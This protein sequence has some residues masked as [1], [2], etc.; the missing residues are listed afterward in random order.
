MKGFIRK[1]VRRACAW[2][3]RWPLAGGCCTATAT[4]VDPCWPERYNYMARQDGRRRLRRPGA[5]RPR[6]RPDDLELPLRARRGTDQ[7]DAGR[8][9]APEVPGPPPA[10]ARPAR[11]SCRR[12]RTSPMT[13]PARRSSP[14]ARGRP[15][16]AARRGRSRSYLTAQTA[17][18]AGR[19]RGRRPR[20]GRRRPHAGALPM[21]SAAISGSAAAAPAARAAGPAAPAAAAVGGASGGRGRRRPAGGDGDRGPLSRKRIRRSPPMASTLASACDVLGSSR[22]HAP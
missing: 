18:P 11:S 10:A 20:P 19:L 9:G 14:Q 12:P 7:A 13:R 5:E 16:H 21:R 4:C 3:R 15:G 22:T 17:R 6:P 1:T 2:A 8:P